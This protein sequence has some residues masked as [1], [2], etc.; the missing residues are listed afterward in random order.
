MLL[1]LVRHAGAFEPDP[2]TW[3]DDRHR[4]LSPQGAERFRRAARGLRVAAPNVDLVLSSPYVRAWQTAELL[5]KDA[6]WPAP[7]VCEPL[8]AG[9]PTAG[10]LATLRQHPTSEAMAL[11]GH[12]PDLHIL[13]SVLLSGTDHTVQAEFKRGATACLEVPDL[14]EPGRVTLLWF[15]SPRIL[16]AI[17]R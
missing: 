7:E 1:Y 14:V 2:A 16:R 6:R 13:L 8:S 15:A 4:P 17:G 3:P 5:Q 9:S 10:V 12:E 11:I